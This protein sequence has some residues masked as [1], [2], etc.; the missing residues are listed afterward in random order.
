MNRFFVVTPLDF[1]TATLQEMKDIWPFLLGKDAKP[2]GLPF[3]D[4]QVLEGGLEFETELVVGV[5]LNFFL[6]TANRVLLRMAS[7]KARDLP[8]FYQ[9]FKSLPWLEYLHSSHVEWKIAAQKSRLNNEKRLQES[10]QSALQEIFPS[11]HSS[12]ASGSIFIRMDDDLCTISL[13]TSGEHLHKR[14]WTALR[15]DAPLRET[16]ASYMLKSLIGANADEINAVTLLDP[17]MGSG[18]LLVEARALWSGQFL[19]PY[20]FQKWK[21]APKLFLSPSFALN[22]E[23]PAQPQFKK[24]LGFDISGNMVSIASANFAE[25]EKQLQQTGKKPFQ[26]AANEFNHVDAIEEAQ[27]PEGSDP[28]WMILNPPY[29][30]RLPVAINGGLPQ[31]ASVL[32][33]RYKPQRIGILYPEKEKISP[34][35]KGYRVLKENRI[36]NGGLRCLFTVLTRL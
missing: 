7:F 36:N 17:M 3:P 12:E 28:L 24:Y 21:K 19:R 5:Q 25:V 16:I 32:C 6:K 31:L 35:P 27:A 2:H 18:T 22:Y 4:V 23:I 20:A 34:A 26:A 9:K 8:K 30:E 14:G 33:S 15:G 13:D 29:G 11:K 10:A 1:E